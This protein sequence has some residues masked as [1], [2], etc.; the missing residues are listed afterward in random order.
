VTDAASQASQAGPFAIEARGLRR[1]FRV[2]RRRAGLLGALRSL[3]PGDSDE[4]VAVRD[5]SFRVARGELVGALGPNGAGR[6]R[7]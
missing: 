4:V 5:V 2:G 3:L 6:A 1:G 7:R